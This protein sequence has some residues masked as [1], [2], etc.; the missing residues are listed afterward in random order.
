MLRY[1]FLL[2]RMLIAIGHEAAHL[3]ELRRPF[4]CASVSSALCPVTFMSSGSSPNDASNDEKAKY[5]QIAP[6]NVHLHITWVI[7]MLGSTQQQF[8]Q[9]VL[10]CNGNVI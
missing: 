6:N 9:N 2:R 8:K 4:A 1:A 7:F 3:R 10:P 5:A